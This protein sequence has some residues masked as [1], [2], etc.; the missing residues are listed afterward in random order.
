MNTILNNFRRGIRKYALAYIFVAVPVMVSVIFL[1]IP[2]ITTLG[3]S[4]T[5]FNGLQPPKFVG[6]DN[7]Y[8]LIT[9]D[10]TFLK[11]LKNTTNFTLWGMLIG[12]TLGLLTAF[13]L[14]QKIRF[15]ALFRAAYF[16]P[17]MTSLVVVA[18]IWRMLYNH[19]GLLNFILDGFGMEPVRWL[20]DP[21]WALFSI[22]I[23]SVW[24]GFGFE[25]V[26][27]L[28]ALQGIPV[29]LYEAATLDGA[30]AWQRFR[31]IT[32]PSLRPVLIFVYIIGIIGSFQIFD[33]VFVMTSGG[34]ANS[35]MT[36]VY[37]Q[38]NK[39]LD[40]RLGYSSA[41]AYMLFIILAIFSYL[42]WRFFTE[43]D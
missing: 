21:R 13:M 23:A 5:E 4:F 30:N 20:S 16:L 3:W 10:K 9:Q 7:Y 8:K 28:A 41:I 32:L 40:L 31:Y 35:T 43:K 14:N 27:F 6:F 12:P 2:M 39:F 38:Y 24:Q 15:Q 37:Y 34:P 22:I 33:Q 1:F 26:I 19:N 11:A 25:T 36:L 18:T 29:V 17:V 42:Q